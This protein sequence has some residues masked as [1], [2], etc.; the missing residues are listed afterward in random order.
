MT[1]VYRYNSVDLGNTVVRLGRLGP[2][3]ENA[4]L[5]NP[6]HGQIEFDDPAGTLN[7][8]GLKGF[9]V[10]ELAGPAAATLTGTVTKSSASTGITGSGTLFLSELTVGRI[11]SI[12]GGGGTDY[13]RVNGISSDTVLSVDANPGHSASG[14]T[15]TATAQQRL[16]SSFLGTR[17]VARGQGDSLRTGVARRWTVEVI[18]FNCF[19]GFHVFTESD[20]NR[21]AETDIERVQWLLTSSFI[22][23]ELIDTGYVQT[24]TGVDMDAADYRLQRPVDLLNDCAQVSGRNFY[25]YFDDGQRV[26]ALWYLNWTDLV[27]ISPVQFS[28]DLTKV[29]SNETTVGAT[30]VFAPE[31]DATLH[32][33]PSRVASGV[34]VPYG[35]GSAFAYDTNAGTAAAFGHLEAVAP[36]SHVT[37]SGKAL[38]LADRY[39]DE[40]NS[41]D[42]TITFS[43]KVNEAVVTLIHSGDIVN[44]HF[45][46]LPGFTYPSGQSVNYDTQ[47]W[48]CRIT[49]LT[50]EQNELSDQ[51]YMLRL[52]V[53]PIPAGGG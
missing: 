51:W 52:N 14:Q 12:P 37:T 18:D 20:A 17:D 27:R 25:S 5:G 16:Y 35:T 29:D 8:V 22:A 30:M 44:C 19:L 24:G 13:V 31:M 41:E 50:Y 36:N 7:I 23:G 46:H 34:A 10:D 26:H 45:T 43:A 6:G 4:Q 42:F 47:L 2:L 21:P 38:A 15:A 32:M 1:Q 48:P 33:G 28:N 53:S 40:N 9:A 49:N 3:T 11:I 39:L